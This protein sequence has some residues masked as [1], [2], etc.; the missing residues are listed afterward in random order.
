MV[1]KGCIITDKFKSEKKDVKIVNDKISEIGENLYDDTIIEADG[2]HLFP[3]LIDLNVRVKDDNL[4]HNSLKELTSRALRG[5]VG[6]ISLMPDSKPA[7][8]NESVLEFIKLKD[9][10]IDIKPLCLGVKSDGKLSDVAT[11]LKRGAKGIVSKSDISGNNLRRL[12]EYAKAKD[13]YLFCEPYSETL[14]DGVMNEG[15]LSSYL[16]LPAVAMVAESSEVA[17]VVEFAKYFNSKLLL[18]SLST[19]RSIELIDSALIKSEVSIHHLILDENSNDNFNTLAKINPPLRDTE[20]KNRMLEL[21]ADNKIDTITSLQSQ[22]SSAKKD[23]AYE[24]ASFGIDCLDYYFSLCYT[25][26]VKSG[27]ISLNKLLEI[28]SFNQAMILKEQSGYIDIGLNAN[29][30]LVDLNNSFKVEFSNSPYFGKEL[31][32]EIKAHFINGEILI[33]SL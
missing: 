8:D 17:K 4:N 21:L 31:F 11:L 16:G 20:S 24:E 30:I 19:P 7:I 33:N 26:L 22:K 14:S 2:L 23:L 6:T 12:F 13:I 32:G 9:S 25:Y 29:L 28:T 27:L 10:K 15:F 1:I 3:S 18:K 5:G